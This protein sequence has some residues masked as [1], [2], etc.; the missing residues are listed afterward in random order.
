LGS[1]SLIKYKFISELL[2]VPT[3]KIGKIGDFDVVVCSSSSLEVVIVP[4]TTYLFYNFAAW[5][6][7][8]EIKRRLI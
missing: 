4:E 7:Y 8:E 6:I 2:T 3:L 1:T 5:N